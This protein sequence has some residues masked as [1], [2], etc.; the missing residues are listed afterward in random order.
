MTYI[1]V[2]IA[3]GD[4]DGF[5]EQVAQAKSAGAE[6][7]ELRL[8]YLQELNIDSAKKIIVQTRQTGLPIIATCRDNKEGGVGD[9]DDDLRTAVLVSAAK[10]GADF[11]DCEYQNFIKNKIAEPIKAALEK[12]DT[13]L[14]LSSHN[15]E[16]KFANLAE[17]YNKIR[18]T[19]EGCV[20]KLVYM[21]KHINDCF[22]VF[23]LLKNKT[24][25]II[26]FAMGQAGVISRIIAKKL[27]SLVSFASLDAGSET[28]SGQIT[29]EDFKNLYRSDI[30]DSQTQIYGIIGDPVTH[31]MSP[32][33]HNAG[34]AAA[35]VNKIYLP[36][37]I[38]GGRREFNE[39]MTNVM[40]RSR[41]EFS[42]FSVT[43]PHKA[44]ALEYLMEAGEYV[45]DLAERIGAVNTI[46][47]GVNGRFSGYN[48][49]YA[50]AMNVIKKVMGAKRH[51]LHKLKVA[52]IG[53]GGAGRAI[54]AGLCDVA[55]KVKV[56]NRTVSK[57]Q[58]LAK[59]FGCS[60]SE[61]SGLKNL[62]ADLVVNCTSIGMSPNVD[63]SPVP[64]GLIKKEMTVFDTVYNPVETLLLKQAADAGAKTID[65]VSMFI[66]Q[67]MAQFKLFTGTDGDAELM[68]KKICE[69]L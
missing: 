9:W 43:L 20:P 13:R 31:S 52:V 2:P 68:R 58:G 27:G 28:A 33:V 61:L 19:H 34:F 50:G 69:F 62:D 14:I 38:Q 8:D 37:L 63:A 10:A 7:V 1:T 23:D 56:Y 15:F 36:I 60:Y 21:A 51:D 49:D 47:V 5:A 65:G 67:A 17:L 35:G 26:A 30:I 42:G 4:L 3:A 41:L 16:G 12:T 57:A 39:F 55:A 48:T 59:E 46:V 32:A 45:E 53:A 40:H 29:I 44:H 64:A 18:F 6:A 66:G 11:I 22:E 54:V 24:G 25:D